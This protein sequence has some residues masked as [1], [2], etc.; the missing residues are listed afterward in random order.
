MMFSK[1]LFS[2]F[3]DFYL[4]M[5]KYKCWER[6][7]THY[8]QSLNLFDFILNKIPL[9]FFFYWRNHIVLMFCPCNTKNYRKKFWIH[10][11]NC[12]QAYLRSSQLLISV[13][14]LIIFTINVV[15]KYERNFKHFTE[16]KWKCIT[17][18]K[19]IWRVL[20]FLCTI[21]DKYILWNIILEKNITPLSQIWDTDSDINCSDVFRGDMGG[22]S[23]E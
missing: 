2:T 7:I 6:N 21:N 14:L 12:H 23:F 16:F 10:I 22:N 1:L 11:W 9:F 17:N 5:R 19:I 8:L 18:T 15:L 13:N 3:V 20:N 4:S